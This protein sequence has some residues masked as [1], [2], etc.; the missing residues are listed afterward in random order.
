MELPPDEVRRGR[1]GAGSTTR[2]PLT[3]AASI[4]DGVVA[5]QIKRPPDFCRSP[6]QWPTAKEA[7]LEG[8]R[9]IAEG[10][11]DDQITFCE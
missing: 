9:G 6:E 7:H 10:S 8:A 2:A 11:G 3:K 1:A 4:D 5:I